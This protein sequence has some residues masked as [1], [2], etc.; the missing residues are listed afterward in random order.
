MKSFSSFADAK[1]FAVERAREIGRAVVVRR[2]AVGWAVDDAHQPQAIDSSNASSLASPSV[3]SLKSPASECEDNIDTG[4]DEATFRWQYQEAVMFAPCHL[5]QGAGSLNGRTCSTCV[6]RG[7]VR[8]QSYPSAPPITEAE[9][10]RRA[11]ASE[12]SA[13]GTHFSEYV[14]IAR[15]LTH[16]SPWMLKTSLVLKGCPA[17]EAETIANH[18]SRH[19]AK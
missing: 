8:R 13:L 10:E 3:P 17:K 4:V 14:Q 12:F 19:D 5:C 6:G 1:R 18:L 16:L 2:E 15:N 7:S 9:R 11:A